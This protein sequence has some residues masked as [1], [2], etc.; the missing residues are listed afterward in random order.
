MADNLT[1]KLKSEANQAKDSLKSG[2]QQARAGVSQSAGRARR[3]IEEELDDEGNPISN[4]AE[5]AGRAMGQTYAEG[6]DLLED[7]A[8]QLRDKV[9]ERPLLMLGGALLA[10]LVLGKMFRS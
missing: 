8:G 1:N 5:K 9:H 10:G 3:D 7:T 2:Y 6:A 4:F